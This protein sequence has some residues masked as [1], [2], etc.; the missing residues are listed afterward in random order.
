MDQSIKNSITENLDNK[1]QL[2]EPDTQG[3]NIIRRQHQQQLKA[4]TIT[5]EIE[6][7]L[8][9]THVPQ[10]ISLTSLKKIKVYVQCQHCSQYIYTKISHTPGVL[11]LVCFLTAA[12]AFLLFHMLFM[13]VFQIIFVFTLQDVVHTC[14]SCSNRIARYKRFEQVT[15]VSPIISINEDNV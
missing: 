15:S 6:A 14:P 12:A 9:S 1:Q 3:E 7:P 8:P 4:H 5:V 10:T 2:T 11:L 13:M